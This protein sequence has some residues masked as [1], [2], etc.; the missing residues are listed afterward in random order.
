MLSRH[1]DK[2]SLTMRELRATYT[3]ST[4]RATSDQVENPSVLHCCNTLITVYCAEANGFLLLF[5]PRCVG[6]TRVKI[7]LGRGW[8]LSH[9]C[10]AQELDNILKR[11]A[12]I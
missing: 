12:F 1:G 3:N 10:G 5:R 11:Q 6:L 4:T 9:K 7:C 8:T 2:I